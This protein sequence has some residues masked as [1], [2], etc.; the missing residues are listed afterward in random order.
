MATVC[1][2]RKTRNKYIYP[3]VPHFLTR[4]MLPLH[5]LPTFCMLSSTPHQGDMSASLP[6]AI[7]PHPG[8]YFPFN[9]FFAAPPRLFLLGLPSSSYSVYGPLLPTMYQVHRGACTA[10]S[11]LTRKTHTAGMGNSQNKGKALEYGVPDHHTGG[12]CSADTEADE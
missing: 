7:Q 10:P 3:L 5:G 1:L 9:I 6:A 8:I 11:T 4:D 12:I 2:K